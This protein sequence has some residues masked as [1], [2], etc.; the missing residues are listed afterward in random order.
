MVPNERWYGSPK[1]AL[2]KLVFRMVGPGAADP[3]VEE[4]RGPRPEPPYLDMVTQVQGMAGVNYH[5]AKGPTFEHVE[6]NLVNRSS[7]D[8]A[9]RKATAIDRKAIVTKTIGA[10]FEAA[11]PLNNRSCQPGVGYKDVVFRNQP[12]TG[13]LARARKILTDAGYRL[14]SGRLF[15][16][17][18]QQ[19]PPL[20]LRFHHG[21]PAPP[22]DR[23]TDPG[24]AQGARY[25]VEDRGDRQVGTTLTSGDFDLIVFA[26]VG[27]PFLHQ[28]GPVDHRRRR[29]RQI[30]RPR[31]G[32]ADPTSTRRRRQRPGRC[33]TRPTIVV[34]ADAYDL[35]LFQKPV[36]LAVY[37]DFVNVRNNPTASGPVL[38]LQGVG[39]QGV[40]SAKVTG[41]STRSP[42]RTW[43]RRRR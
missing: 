1:P 21:Q 7:E 6:L 11:E 31:G 13:D 43:R 34:S 40:A 5:L 8:P 37:A 10:F 33:S 24:T 3:R 12:G 30:R 16:K 26:F 42:M 29:L 17:D 36:F 15:T 19:I 35:T 14:D 41:T 23:R 25:R 27:S 18:G 38:R 22:A 4:Q 39:P 2:E 20:R 9:L 32:P 28:Q